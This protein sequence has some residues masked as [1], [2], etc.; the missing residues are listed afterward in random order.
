MKIIKRNGSEVEFDSTKI[1]NA[2]KGANKDVE[3][4]ARLDDVAINGIAVKITDI[5]AALGR[6]VSVEEVQDLVENQL[7]S[8]GAF[9]LARA[10]ITYRYERAL[11]RKANSTDDS[12][13][14][15]IELANEEIKQ[16]NS[17]KNPV[18]VSVQRDYMAGEVSKD[19]TKRLLLPKEIWEAHESGII[20]FHEKSWLNVVVRY[21]KRGE[22]VNAGCLFK[23][24]G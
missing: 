13:L 1:V 18:V 21:E 23:K 17:N 5:C 9:E 4:N 24:V 7:M 19:L 11:A 15:L 10:Y 12:I 2:I 6:A 3:E 16:E 8:L 22:P 20:H 14:S